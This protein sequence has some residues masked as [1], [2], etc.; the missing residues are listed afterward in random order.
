MIVR[1]T[2]EG[3]NIIAGSDTA[4]NDSEKVPFPT[5]LFSFI[6]QLSEQ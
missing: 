2:Y 5:F 6:V 4:S 1:S 3:S